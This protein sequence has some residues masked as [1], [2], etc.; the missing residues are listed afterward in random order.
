[1][2]GGAG[3]D[4]TSGNPDSRVKVMTKKGL[5]QAKNHKRDTE[6]DP[7]DE[8]I[9]S[10]KGSGILGRQVVFHREFPCSPPDHGDISRPWPRE[11][12]QLLDLTGIKKFYSHQAKAMDLIRAGANVVVATPTASGKS[13]IYNL[14]ILERILG[15][16]SSKAL[17][18]FP[19][20]A[21]AQDQL[22]SLNRLCAC[23][24]DDRA[25]EAALYDGDTP[26]TARTR[27]RRMPP[28]LLLTN[29]EMLHLSLLPY[30]QSWSDFWTGLT[31]VVLDEVHTY[32][33][34]L[35]SH[36]AWVLRR[37]NRVCKLYG[38]SPTFISC[39]ATIGNPGELVST[40]TGEN[41]IEITHSGA[42]RGRR[43]M[44]FI[45]P[46]SGAAQTAILL[47][48]AALSRG[49]K[50]IVYS[51]SRKL[52][53]LIGM[54]VAGRAG[55]YKKR[56][57]TYRAGYL[58]E[59]RRAIERDLSS[60]RL[61]AVIST[62]ALE[63]G[64]D[65]GSLDLCILVGYPGT[66]TATWQRGGRVGR[67]MRNS[68]IVLIAQEDALDQYFMR[69][70]EELLTRPPEAAVINPVNPVIMARHLE[71]AAVES[72]ICLNEPVFRG[73]N[74]R[75]SLYGLEKKTKL[76]L[77]KE[78]TCFHPVRK[79]PHRKINLRGAGSSFRIISEKTR[80]A[81]GHI[82]GFRAFRETHPGAVYIHLGETYV[83]SQLDVET[84]Q[85]VVRRKKVNYFTRVRAEKNTSILEIFEE[86]SSWNSRIF[87]GRLRVT[88]RVT[89]YE[90]RSV[91][92]NLSMGKFDLDMPAQVFE[93]EGFWINVPQRVQQFIQAKRMHFMG[94]IHAIEHAM[95]GILPLFVLTDR[96][97]L[98]GI[99]TT[100]HP[101]VEGAAI[102]VY[103]GIPGGAGL[104]RQAF[105]DPEELLERTLKTIKDCPCETGCPSCVHSPKC[106][107][108]NRPIDKEAAIT[109]L[110]HMKNLKGTEA[111]TG[112]MAAIEK[113]GEKDI[114]KIPPAPTRNIVSNRFGV[115]DLETQLSAQE[116]GGWHR[117]DLMKISC[118]VAYDAKKNQ[119][120]EFTENEINGFI[121][122]LAGLDLV[123]GF[124]IKKF[125][126]NVLRGYSSFDFWGLPT[127]DILEEVH[128]RLGY[129]L[130]LDHLARETLGTQ[131]SANG[132][133]A[134]TWWKQGKIDK[135][136]RYCRKDV[137]ITRD[138]YLYGREHGHLLFK[139][140]AGDRVRV[141]VEW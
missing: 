73:K 131:K 24:P 76:L 66:I 43:H 60:G 88:D 36:M 105:K 17:Y 75:Q 77:N 4:G 28:S 37:M 65:I 30:H 89:G 119:Y 91:K 15:E 12:R 52:T 133:Q 135:I 16:P 129:R 53:E 74:I 83:V 11:I 138:L 97:D 59:E 84:Q 64:I 9:Q 54:W 47:L 33:G 134:L 95:I 50:T 49:L 110:E 29:P 41:V 69:N 23:L 42:A 141:P 100:F 22:K 48:R 8:Y 87:L 93:T 6:T 90:R 63:L 123:I 117:A 126:Y 86:R 3:Q 109:I 68:A 25:P 107:S 26:Q 40:L 20:K 35:G 94:G 137:A 19:L 103:D 71:C 108:G 34:V 51:Q 10:L 57:G 13:L 92:G 80:K 67:K 45:N 124:N 139:N 125:D 99:S 44:V 18:I 132:L 5:S 79:Y 130:S 118:A 122:Y 127:L 2:T 101:Q 72:P 136:I 78:G 115:F 113:Q 102:F 61:L 120:L 96:G 98:G 27:L 32:R 140:K 85:V 70:P 56:I 58:P 7:I 14:P 39:S 81:V 106:G 114:K 128:K 82:D 46:D 31:H 111:K 38:S 21:L 1:M 62:S 121:E 112:K 55:R 104:S 116:V